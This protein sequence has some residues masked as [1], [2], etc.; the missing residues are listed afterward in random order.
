MPPSFC[1]FCSSARTHHSSSTWLKDLHVRV[2]LDDSLC[3]FVSNKGTVTN[4]NCGHLL[5]DK[6]IADSLCDFHY[7]LWLKISTQVVH[8]EPL[9]LR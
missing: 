4:L 8:E 9:A 2:L 5:C 7:I 1:L 6:N 3:S